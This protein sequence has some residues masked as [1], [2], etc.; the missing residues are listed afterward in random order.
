L[1]LKCVET[2]YV[3]VPGFPPVSMLLSRGSTPIT[4]YIRKKCLK[5]SNKVE[6][7]PRRNYA[8]VD[9]T[10]AVYWIHRFIYTYTKYFMDCSF[11]SLYWLIIL[12]KLGFGNA[13]EKDVPVFLDFVVLG[14]GQLQK[15]FHQFQ[16]LQLKYLSFLLYLPI[17]LG[18]LSH[19]ESV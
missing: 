4:W 12:D 14:I 16:F 18:Q 5:E 11:T 1:D 10:W 19:N 9:K 6:S 3:F 13:I 8:S 2:C 15:Q 7:F 17:S